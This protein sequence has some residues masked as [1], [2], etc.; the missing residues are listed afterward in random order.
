MNYLKYALHAAVVLGVG[1]A[2][3]R[4][5]D[6]GLILAALGQYTL[7]VVLLIVLIPALQLLAKAVRFWL[8]VR[9]RANVSAGVPLRAYA[10][11]QPATLFPGGVAARIGLMRQAGVSVGISS[12]AVLLS[13]L[14]DQLLS[15]TGLALSAL[16][17]PS[18]RPAALVVLVIVAALA[19]SALLPAVRRAAF[20]MIRRLAFRFGFEEGWEDFVRTAREGL[21]GRV[22]LLA[23]VLSAL[24]V[25]GD[26]WLLDLCLRGVG[27]TLPLAALFPAYL[28][29][30]MLGKVSALPAGGIGVAE[31]GMIGY[32]V[33]FSSISPDE[34]AA[35][36][37]V[38][39]VAAV[40]L[41]AL[42]GALVYLFFWRAEQ[43]GALVGDPEPA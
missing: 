9:Q 31:A 2:A 39:R 42:F 7:S 25:A 34:A 8:F 41:Q 16:L 43:E 26:V 32:L 38:F 20:G 12:A 35:A 17:V 11:G 10:A 5:L 15:V 36:V 6:I 24:A 33:A 23:F 30:T 4:Y 3:V 19:L 13:S 18:V 21:S 40:F 14:L 22:L 29:P 27:Y 28:L 37:A 1:V